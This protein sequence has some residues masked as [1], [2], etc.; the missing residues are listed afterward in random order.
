MK[1]YGKSR[2][3]LMETTQASSIPSDNS[4]ILEAT[5]DDA[6]HVEKTV[7]HACWVEDVALVNGVVRKTGVGVI[8]EGDEDNLCAGINDTAIS[9]VTVRYE[10]LQF[11]G[12]S[13]PAVSSA[14][15]SLAS[16]LREGLLTRVTGVLLVLNPLCA[17]SANNSSQDTRDV[18]EPPQASAQAESEPPQTPA[19]IA[20][21]IRAQ[22]AVEEEKAAAATYALQPVDVNSFLPAVR[23]SAAQAPS[24][25][26]SKRQ[27]VEAAEQ[28][29][30]LIGIKC[31]TLKEGKIREELKRQLL[32]LGAE[33]IASSV[34]D[35]NAPLNLVVEL[36]A[37]PGFKDQPGL[38]LNA[39]IDTIPHWPHQ[40][41]YFT[42]EEMDFDATRGEF[43]HTKEHSFGAD[44]RAGVS[45]LLSA[46]K[47]AHS[48][49]W[50]KG[51]GHRKIVLLFTAQEEIGGRGATYL[52]KEHP[53]I[54]KDVEISLTT[55]GPLNYGKEYP[56]HSYIVVVKEETSH[57]LPFSRI[58]GFVREMSAFKGVS[59]AMTTAG[60]GTGD[61][62]NFPPEAKSDLHIRA[63]YQGQHTQERVKLDDLFNHIDLFT[64][65]LLRLD[66]AS[67]R[68]NEDTS[69]LQLVEPAD[70]SPST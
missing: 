34:Q 52:A 40:G 32:P 4:V 22:I 60:L 61:F 62:A 13:S 31:S 41:A 53:K 1:T 2:I 59:F 39:H 6:A 29:V 19:Q 63:P 17:A 18:N 68:L 69:R 27:R 51:V 70:G 26:L 7:G 54:F 20:A 9:A 67:L 16:S 55:D 58:V 64:Y 5:P 46:I 47:T 48:G 24:L 37:T 21:A 43:F 30:R 50:E 66:G 56:E 35:P 65:I 3:E 23:K 12:V 33:E 11:T 38:I 10:Q 8:R 25:F 45:V 57:I 15:R 49:Y 28:L 36:S 14:L 42:P 44:D